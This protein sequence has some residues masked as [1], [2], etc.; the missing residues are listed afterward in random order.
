VTPSS[1]RML[2]S[3]ARFAQSNEPMRTL[4]AVSCALTVLALAGCSQTVTSS[5]PSATH[6]SNA[7]AR[8]LAARGVESSADSI[9]WEQVGP[10]WV[11]AT[12]SP[13]AGHR[14]GYM[15]TNE[16]DP[17]TVSMTLYLV[18]PE[19]GRYPITTFPPTKDAPPQLIDWSGDKNRALFTTI[20]AAGAIE[21][22]LHTGKQTP[23]AL[24]DR[25]ADPRYTLPDGK[26]LLLTSGG[27]QKP[28]TLTRVDLTG[29]QQLSYPV[30]PDYS[31]VL[32]TPDGTQ[33]V[34]GTDTGLALMGNDGKPGRALL[35]AGPNRC[36]PLRWWDA[37]STVLAKCGDGASQLW[38][39]P[40]DGGA[41]SA[42]TAVN[43]GQKG[44]DY[45]DAN[46][47][48]LP[49]GTFLQDLGACGVIYLAKLNADGTTTEVNVPDVQAG[50]I[51]V[52][53]VNGNSLRLHARAACGGGLSIV[54]YD[55]STNVSSVLLGPPI[56]GGG[57]IDAVAFKGQR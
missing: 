54:D 56:N 57:V 44:P 52:I 14:P 8:P 48:Q 19:G 38:R 29:K 39:V 46:A 9:P 16:P 11:L 32:S 6:A 23:I 3:V 36:R 17:S 45:G 40:I 34:V 28:A 22:D 30:A 41:P 13:L 53:G 24:A 1:A 2:G 7:S 33:L 15:P 55:P 21:V 31:G 27:Y 50:S 35:V 5:Q 12:W 4:A 47:W 37:D 49:A 42:L 20:G 43:D 26:A 10:G 18:D 25:S 51:E